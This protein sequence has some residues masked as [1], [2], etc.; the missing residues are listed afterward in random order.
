MVLRREG[1]FARMVIEH[2]LR[3]ITGNP[4]ARLDEEQGA[5]IQEIVDLNE[6]SLEV[7]TDEQIE[8]IGGF[9]GKGG[10]GEKSLES[11][12]G[13]QSLRGARN[14]FLWGYRD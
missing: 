4:D 6:G 3:E 2:D 12:I 11:S 9:Q 14:L 8:A 7:S 5:V 1:V 13:A 10:N